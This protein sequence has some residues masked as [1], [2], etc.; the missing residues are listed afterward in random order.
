M[1]YMTPLH[2][3]S[4]PAGHKHSSVK[5]DCCFTPSD[6]YV[7]GS[8]GAC[9]SCLMPLDPQELPAA[10]LA[11]AGRRSSLLHLDSCSTNFGV[12][13]FFLS[14]RGWPR[15]L[16]GAC[17]G[18]AGGRCIWSL[19]SA[20][21]CMHATA[22]AGAVGCQ[23]AAKHSWIEYTAQQ[24]PRAMLPSPAH[25]P[26]GPALP[27]QIFTQA[28]TTAHIFCAA[29]GVLPGARG[30]GVQHGH[31][32]Q[33]RVPADQLRGWHHQGVGVKPRWGGRFHPAVCC[34]SLARAHITCGCP[35]VSRSAR[36]CPVQ[37][38]WS[39]CEVALH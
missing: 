23:L 18:A 3:Q 33:G 35:R 36:K 6:A 4:S 7:V 26:R 27:C 22:H 1:P 15:L 21:A 25:P 20:P 28:H 34:G 32:P 8:S 38:I 19:W 12:V 14:C 29:G 2:Y 30:R 24:D 39:C 9:S 31:A 37:C 5:M 10:L 17:G 13:P 11:S 16:L